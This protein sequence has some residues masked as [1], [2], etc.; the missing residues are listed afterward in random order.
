MSNNF[1]YDTTSLQMSID[2]SGLTYHPITTSLY[3]YTTTGLYQT[4]SQYASISGY[5]SSSTNSIVLPT[6][7]ANATK[8]Y[9]RFQSST[10]IG[11]VDISGSGNLTIR[12]TGNLYCNKNINTTPV[13][14]LNGLTS[15]IQSQLNYNSNYQVSLSSLINT[16]FINQINTNNIQNQYLNSLSGLVYIN[17]TYQGNVNNIQSNINNFQ[18]QNLNSLSG[19][20][21]YNFLTQIGINSYQA[22]I[23]NTNTIY[24]NTLS[25]I[26]YS[27]NLYLNSLSGSINY[28]QQQFNNLSITQTRLNMNLYSISAYIVNSSLI[29]TRDL[30]TYQL[31][32]SYIDN[33]YVVNTK[34]IVA[35]NGYYLTLSSNIISSYN[36]NTY[37]LS[38]YQL[39]SQYISNSYLISARSVIVNSGYY[40]TLSSNIITCNNINSKN[41][42]SENGLF[43]QNLTC[44]G[45]LTILELVGTNATPI[46][47][48]LVVQHSD[49]NGT[50]SIVF[51]SKNNYGS[52][53]GF[54]KFMDDIYNSGGENARLIIGVG[55]DPTSPLQDAIILW[56]CAG[57]GSVGINTLYPNNAYSLD[58]KGDIHTN[59]NIYGNNEYISNNLIVYNNTTLSGNVYINGSTSLIGNKCDA[60]FNSIDSLNSMVCGGH[61]IISTI[62]WFTQNLKLDD[63]ATITVSNITFASSNL[64]TL[65]TCTSNIQSQLNNKLNNNQSG[66]ITGDLTITGTPFFSS[67]SNIPSSIKTGTT[68]SYGLS[69][70]WNTNQGTGQ[71]DFL[72]YA[73]GGSGGFAFHRI[74]SSGF[75]QNLATITNAGVSSS[76]FP[77]TSDYRIKEN[78]KDL[79]DTFNIDKL[80]PVSYYNKLTEKQD[81]GL[82]A[83]ELQEHYPY[84]VNNN[85]DDDQLQSVNYIALISV[86]IKEIQDLKKIV[87][88]MK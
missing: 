62:G 69:I 76:A 33:L 47:G 60:I 50:S 86:L 67:N 41:L 14:Y 85:K 38:T 17:Y 36:I 74:N 45:I 28:L 84:L 72:N 26:F 78:V 32:S 29:N 68:A 16:N 23:N 49:T 57:N 88:N 15:N 6:L 18:T 11:N 64:S 20:V 61:G 71:S 5:F 43:T 83:H 66:T 42:V 7:S 87:Y 2:I 25:G 12:G 4:V 9:N 3:N 10:F 1:F 34:F 22:K 73:Q 44:D 56:S 82:I 65:S 37:N 80:R 53:F 52:D 39:N 30:S 35:I 8:Y 46:A 48:S 54:I 55:D 21:N 13:I 63:I 70:Y 75:S 19:L 27:N 24:F 81:M 59:S 79:D 40:L 58:V 31:Y 77:T 51:P